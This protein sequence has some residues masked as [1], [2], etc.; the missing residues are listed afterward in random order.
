MG[1]AAVLLTAVPL[2]VGADTAIRATYWCKGQRDAVELTA[3]FFNEP[4]SAV[5]LLV[6]EGATRLPQALSASGSR[7]S[8]G[9]QSFWVKGDQA[10]WELGSGPAYTCGPTRP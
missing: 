1:S 9:R 6:G 3:L 2:P 8:D 7:Y 5:V 10:R 4:P